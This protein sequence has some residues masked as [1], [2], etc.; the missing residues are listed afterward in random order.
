MQVNDNFTSLVLFHM[1]RVQKIIYSASKQYKTI[2]AKWINQSSYFFERVKMFD[3]V[4]DN[5][6]N[7]IKWKA[8]GK[9]EVTAVR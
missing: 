3:H 1:L 5:R 8:V 4:K 7:T 2:Y 6:M 9:T